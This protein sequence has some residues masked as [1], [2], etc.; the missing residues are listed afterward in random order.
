MPEYPARKKKNKKN[1]LK[2]DNRKIKKEKKHNKELIDASVNN[3]ID[4]RDESKIDKTGENITGS[5]NEVTNISQNLSSNDYEMFTYEDFEEKSDELNNDSFDSED[6]INEENNEDPLIKKITLFISYIW[7][8]CKNF[9]S[10]INRIISK[11]KD[12]Y[13]NIEYKNYLIF[14]ANKSC[15]Y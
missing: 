2:K 5:E 6:N 14:F 13:N 12:I 4:V 1:K 9:S 11:I 10:K 8:L 15:I 3:S 7:D